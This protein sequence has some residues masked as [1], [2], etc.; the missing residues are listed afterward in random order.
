MPD[1][2]WP[3]VEHKLVDLTRFE[4][5]RF[6][7]DKRDEKFYGFG[8]ACN[9]FYGEVLLYANTSDALRASA[10]RS[11]S[12]YPDLNRYAGKSLAEVEDVLRWEMGDWK[13][14]GFNALSEEWADGWEEWQM[15]FQK[16]LE[17]L[18]DGDE[19]EK[20][21]ALEQEFLEMCC[22]A[23]IRLEKQPE[24]IALPKDANFRTV[25][26]NHDEAESDGEA[27]LSRIRSGG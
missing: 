21:G 15:S 26:D 4:V 25:C 14:D 9:A 19:E 16:L 10:E 24:F 27:R 23:L 2:D 11:R 13:Y 5:R 1:I 22:R 12:D 17:G 20:A 8:F 7:E 3:E 6:L 18:Y